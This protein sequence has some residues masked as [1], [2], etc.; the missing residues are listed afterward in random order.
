MPCGE[1]G[2]YDAKLVCVGELQRRRF[3]I[4]N[5]RRC[6]YRCARACTHISPVILLTATAAVCAGRVCYCSCSALAMGAPQGPQQNLSALTRNTVNLMVTSHFSM[7]LNERM[8]K[9]RIPGWIK[10]VYLRYYRPSCTFFGYCPVEGPSA[11]P[12]APWV[13]PS[14][15]ATDTKELRSQCASFRSAIARSH[16]GRCQYSLCANGLRALFPGSPRPG[17]AIRGRKM[18]KPAS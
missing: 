7:G 12:F 4:T 2:N 9:P 3:G 5:G 15:A 10:S 16:C 8:P 14:S 1:A 17:V 6:C 18:G 11:A 13:A